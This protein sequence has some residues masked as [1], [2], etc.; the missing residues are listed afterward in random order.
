MDTLVRQGSVAWRK[1]G[2]VQD[3]SRN[4]SAG[5]AGVRVNRMI[6]GRAA[7]RRAATRSSPPYSSSFSSPGRGPRGVERRRRF[8]A[9]RLGRHHGAAPYNYQSRVAQTCDKGW[10]DDRFNR[11]QIHCY[12]TRDVAR[13]CDPRE[14]R[15]LADK[16]L[17]FQAAMDR[18][19]ARVDAVAFHMIGNPGGDHGDGIGGGE[20][21]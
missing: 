11:D 3:R 15:A 19:V 13:L 4:G 17:A 2:S 14:R 16:L 8:Q 20:E 12:M 6:R 1:I 10:K 18:S 7:R 21:P 9:R 5:Q